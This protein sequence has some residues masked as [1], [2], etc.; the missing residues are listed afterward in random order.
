MWPG[1]KLRRVSIWICGTRR[2]GCA[3]AIVP[4][5]CEEDVD[6]EIDAAAGDEE[7]AD[8]RDWYC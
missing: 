5:Q 2:R 8:G 3:V 4:E 6:E 7:D 1:K